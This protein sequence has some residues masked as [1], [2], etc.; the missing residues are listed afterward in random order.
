MT[1]FRGCCSTAAPS[2]EP[3]LPVIENFGQFS[4]AWKWLSSFSFFWQKDFCWLDITRSNGLMFRCP[5]REASSENFIAAQ[6]KT[7]FAKQL[8]NTTIVFKTMIL[9]KR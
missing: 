9:R 7:K 8:G 4:F 2:S 1:K 3:P 6:R 5:E